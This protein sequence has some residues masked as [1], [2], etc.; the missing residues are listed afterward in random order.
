MT[1]R[2]KRTGKILFIF[3]LGV[4]VF[5]AAFVIWYSIDTKIT[6][7]KVDEQI[8]NQMKRVE[9]GTN[10]YSVGN[11]WL[12]KNQ[13]GLWEMYLEGS[14][15]E[16][17]VANGKL[18]KELIHKQ[19]VAFVDKIRELVPSPGYLNFLKYFV[20]FFNR[21]I[22]EYILPEYEEEIYGISFSASDEFDFIG[23]NYERMLNYH[24][25]HDIGHALQ[26]LMLVGCTSFAANMGFA[27]SSLVI[28][29][30][31]DF[32]ISDAFAEDKIVCF[33]NPEKGHK[34]TYVTWASFIGVVSGMND[35]GLTVTINAGKSDIPIKAATPIS[36][37]AREI[38][39]YAG[40]IE[41][42]IAI[43]KKR[44]T[45]VAESL[46]IG[47]ALDN[48]AVIIEKSPTKID[49]FETTDEFLVCSNHFQGDEFENDE[50]NFE[51]KI[52]TATDY[53]QQRAEELI[54]FQDTVSVIRAAEILRNTEGLN[55]ESIGIGNEKAMAQMISHHSVIFQPLKR[56]LWVSTDPWQFGEYLGYDQ[57]SIFENPEI[58]PGINVFDSTLT[59][60]SDP[61]LDTEA[62]KNFL[63][64][65]KE[66]LVLQKA[67][68]EN[69]T[70][71]EDFIE[72]YLGLNPDYFAGYALAGDYYAAIGDPQKGISFYEFA[73]TKEVEKTE[74]RK[75]IEEKIMQLKK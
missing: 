2:R 71:D 50:A 16:M 60:P 45:F 7:P 64:F 27:D 69:T 67:I 18:T 52:N 31:F 1:S 4:F 21:D 36:L 53:R 14:P 42:A 65:R 44:K 17:G 74:Q 75:E 48:R 8:V 72:S 5:L 22:D 28:G 34:F 51:H 43:A 25:A 70:L 66:T 63:L 47:S 57:K 29:R 15:F 20:S 38:L 46:L 10:S 19:E 32:Y 23:T 55:D 33:V 24:G 9:T 49:V 37:V 26:D 41:E 61:F 40:N 58:K 39:Q 56:R 59:I 54:L 11:N 68:R 13:Y 35:Q 12:R 73:L 6:P 30:N 62:F 3:L